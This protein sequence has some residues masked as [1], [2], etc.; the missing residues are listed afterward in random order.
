VGG[1][2]WE[3]G[4]VRLLELLT[5]ADDRGDGRSK[6]GL[7]VVGSGGLLDLAISERDEGRSISIIS[8]VEGCGSVS[9]VKEKVEQVGEENS[10]KDS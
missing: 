10:M 9:E 7:G 2:T 8:G 5:C 6:C 4:E 3:S 1:R